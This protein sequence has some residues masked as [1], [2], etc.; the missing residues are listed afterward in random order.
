MIILHSRSLSCWISSANYPPPVRLSSIPPIGEVWIFSE[1]S[2]C[3]ALLLASYIH[4][5]IL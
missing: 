4:I 5:Q 2:S 3:Q 1:I